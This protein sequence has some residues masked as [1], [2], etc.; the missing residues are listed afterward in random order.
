MGPLAKRGGDDD[1]AGDDENVEDEVMFGLEEMDGEYEVVNNQIVL[2]KAKP[3]KKQKASSESKEAE[4][5]QQSV[6]KEKSKKR[7]RE[8]EG[9]DEEKAQS[10]EEDVAEALDE[11]DHQH[12]EDDD[13]ESPASSMETESVEVETKVDLPEWEVFDLH[14]YLLKGLSKLGFV[15][16][17]PIQKLSIPAVLLKGKDVMGVAETG[18]GK[19]LAY[20]L[21]ILSFF[22]SN[23]PAKDE[24]LPALIVT[25]TRELAIQIVDHLRKVVS[26]IP[27]KLRPRIDSLVGGMSEQKQE[28]VLSKQPEVVVAT[29][30]RFKA[31]IGRHDHLSNLKQSLR[32]LVVDEADR[33]TDKAHYADI[34]PLL[35][36]LH[37]T[38]E[39]AKKFRKR[40]TLLFSAT[41]LNSEDEKGTGGASG[42]FSS[43]KGGKR[44]KPI[45]PFALMER[46]GRRGEPVICSVAKSEVVLRADEVK[47][48]LSSSSKGGKKEK[49]VGDEGDD[50]LSNVAVKLPD[51]ISF[52]RVDCTEED[53]ETFLHWIISKQESGTSTL[54]FVNTINATKKLASTVSLSFPNLIVATLHANM[55]Q[56]QRLRH[57]DRFKGT[58]DPKK[59]QAAKGRVLIASDVAARGLD[60]PDV[61][62]VIHYGIPSRVDTFI[63]RSGR[64]GRAGRKGTVVALCSGLDAKHMG[65]IRSAIAPRL[66]EP[67]PTKELELKKIV[68]RVRVCKQLAKLLGEQR[69][70]SLD[71]QWKKK[72]AEAELD[73][74]SDMELDEKDP[75]AEDVTVNRAMALKEKSQ[76]QEQMQYE[77]SRLRRELAFLLSGKAEIA[78]MG[79]QHRRGRK[80]P[81]F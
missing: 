8:D 67:F 11:K 62:T 22:L 20:G 72:A 69:D 56:K 52:F 6:L 19:T 26:E 5:K 73:V 21:P 65:K 10:E 41:L 49:A 47:S 1:E 35:D 9:D 12:A 24:G 44:Q 29:M 59:Q 48:H 57:L 71:Q 75:E 28:R 61:D 53:K 54:V 81:K 14:P 40:Q 7:R 68:A 50:V 15:R 36:A 4:A 30:G 51:S 46:L 42:G 32:F 23:P 31:W 64:C 33:M 37:Y 25:P 43:K 13:E 76:H 39:E 78:S 60:I 34:L 74:G 3:S 79:G 18:S 38:E 70:A 55:E 63:H 17:T 80:R 45:G 77:I 27:L 16:P 58:I 2:K 66:L